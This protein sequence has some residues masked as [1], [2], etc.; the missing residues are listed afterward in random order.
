MNMKHNYMKYEKI[1]IW[2]VLHLLVNIDN[3]MLN[4]WYEILSKCNYL[5]VNKVY[6]YFE[7]CKFHS[8]L[9]H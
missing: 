8:F 6:N 1:I 5:I 7:Y 9:L 3:K 4:N 2:K